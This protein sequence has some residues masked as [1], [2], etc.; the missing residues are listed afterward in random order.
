MK[1][2]EEISELES[3]VGYWLRFVS[4][5]VSHAFRLKVELQGVTVAE[6]VVLRQLLEPG[7]VHPSELADQLGLSR[8]AISKLIARLCQKKL[9][10]RAAAGGDQRFQWVELTAAGRKLVPRLA[11]LADDND[12][13]FFGHLSAA[14]RSQLVNVL[15]EI[16][17]RH[18]W[19][20]VPVA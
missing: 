17:C 1:P 12:R 10:R 11:A 19:R 18:G 4:N 3:H 8:G 13:E 6:W 5:H 14:Q 15:N 2:P 9:A 7:Q 20:D 16:V